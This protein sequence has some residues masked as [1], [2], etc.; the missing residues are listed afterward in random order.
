MDCCVLCIIVSS[1]GLQYPVTAVHSAH[2]TLQGVSVVRP[3]FTH[4]DVKYPLVYTF[5]ETV[6]QGIRGKSLLITVKGAMRCW[7]A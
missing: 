7:V 6:P 3:C 1:A 4:S 2:A 5:S